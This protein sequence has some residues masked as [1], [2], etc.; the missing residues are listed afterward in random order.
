MDSFLGEIRAFGFN[1]SP[2]EWAN[3]IGTV[4]SIQQNPALYSILGNTYGGRVGQSFALPNLQGCAAMGAGTGPGLT[5]RALGDVDGESTEWLTLNEIPNHTHTMAWQSST[6]T[7]EKTGTPVV[8]GWPTVPAQSTVNPPKII[9]G[10]LNTPQ[11]N[12]VMASQVLSPA[13][14]S[15]LQ[16]HQNKQPYLPL[17]FCI[18][19]YGEWPQKP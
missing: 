8:N 13:G 19:L 15:N 3:C 11:P 1:F 10:F 17:I 14:T 7:A 16:P 9:P 5:P 12:A 18:S 2:Y 4:M 6:V